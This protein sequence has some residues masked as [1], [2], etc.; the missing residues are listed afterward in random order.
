MADDPVAK[1][2]VRYTLPERLS[3]KP[4][5]GNADLL[6]LRNMLKKKEEEESES[7]AN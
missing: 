1:V 4:L 6:A 5:K 3:Y 2:K 7:D